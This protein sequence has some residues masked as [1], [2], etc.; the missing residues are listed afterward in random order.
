VDD[1]YEKDVRRLAGLIG[2][3]VELSGRPIEAVAAAAGLNPEGLAEI[4]RAPRS[5][6]WL[7]SSG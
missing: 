6:R 4:F 1:P 2:S 5:W 3:L 7:I